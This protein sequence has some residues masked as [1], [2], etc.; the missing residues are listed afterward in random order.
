[1][2]AAL[3]VLAA[4]LA[5]AGAARAQSPEALHA[6]HEQRKGALAASP[7]QRPLLVESGAA[8]SNRPAGEIWAV[9]DQPFTQAL[10][11]LQPAGA[12]CEI[13]L[14]Q[15]NVKRCEVSGSSPQAL[16]QVAV[17]KKDEPTGAQQIAF[18][19][20]VQAATP[21][22]LAVQMQAASGPMGTRDYRLRM[23]A[24]PL[25][26]GRRTVVHMSYAY[27][28]GVTARLATDAY[29]ATRGRDK[30]GFSR[31]KDG[32]YVRGIQ[33]VAERNTMRYFLALEAFLKT[34][35]V[36][37]PQQAQARLREWFAA[38]ERYPQQLHEMSWAEYAQMKR[39]VVPG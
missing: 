36:P 22:Y 18:E 9:L 26:G 23:E 10:P 39:S 30:L 4:L 13:L 11:A 5:L 28:T 32:G 33:G 6:G 37:P 3:V 15:L 35:S 7:F 16:L 14:L 19:Y 27:S 24:A 31:D 20:A 8:S 25:D 2:R 34:L 21:E 1:M 12:W 29:L 17:G 38:T